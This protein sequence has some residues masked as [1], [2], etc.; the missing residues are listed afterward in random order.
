VATI[1]L[2]PIYT[3]IDDFV[4]PLARRIDAVLAETGAER[5]ILVGHSMGGLVARAYLQRYGEVAGGRA[6]DPGNATPGQSPGAHRLW[7][8]RPPD[9]ARQPPGCGPLPNRRR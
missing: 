4:D 9:A 7:R 2:E 3:S 8:E 1:N 5:L 6:S